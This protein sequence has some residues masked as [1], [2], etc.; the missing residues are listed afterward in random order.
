MAVKPETLFKNRIRP[1]LERL[2]NTWIAKIQ[3]VVIRGTP[4][5]LCC[6]NGLF[7]ALELKATPKDK[8]DPLQLWTHQKILDARGISLVVYP[9]NWLEV[10]KFLESIARRHYDKNEVPKFS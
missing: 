3:Q 5:F 9:G 10:Y 1:H 2:P 7:V 4:D 6:V 8:Q